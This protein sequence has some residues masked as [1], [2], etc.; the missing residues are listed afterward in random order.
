[1]ARP[2]RSEPFVDVG[3]GE[4]SP[5]DRWPARRNWSPRLVADRR[6][7]RCGRSHH[8]LYAVHYVALCIIHRAIYCILY[9]KLCQ[10]YTTCSILAARMRENGERMRKWRGNW[11]RM[12]KW[13]GNGEIMRKWREIHSL[14]FLIF[15]LFPPSL[16]ISYIKI[17]HILSQMSKKHS[18]LA[19]RKHF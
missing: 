15:L 4:H 11:G 19:L 16:S 9:Y 5:D 2:Q 7:R 3:A 13:G 12:R 18:I 1:M 17:C 8:T 14:N 6:N 10:G